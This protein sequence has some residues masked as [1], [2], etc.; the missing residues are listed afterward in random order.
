MGA[1]LIGHE[2][3]RHIWLSW[4]W[5]I[6]PSFP[7]RV[8]R[9]FSTGVREESRL[10]E[11]LRGIGATVW[12]TDPNTG[13]QWRV[14]AVRGHFGGSLDGVAQGLPEAPKTPAVLEFK[15]H[16]HKSFTQVIEQR[17]R[18]AKPQ[19]Y[20]Q[21]QIYMGLMELDRAL[22]MAVDKDTDDVYC[23][24]VHFDGERFEQ[25]MAKAERLVNAAE[26]PA[27][28]S[29]DP[30]FF[31]CKWCNFHSLC[32]GGS[33]A[34]ANCRT[35]CHATP[36]ENATWRCEHHGTELQEHK[37]R[38]GCEQHLMIPALVPYAEPIDGGSAWVAYK[39]RASGKTFVNGLG[40]NDTTY[41]PCF[42]SKELERCP[43]ELM[44]DVIETKAQFPSAT[45]VAG[46]R[47]AAA[48]DDMPNDI[49]SA[50]VKPES[51]VA[52]QK[53]TRNS[54]TLKAL[55]EFKGA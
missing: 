7:G 27:R 50:P 53:R 52:K 47:S 26:P 49:D 22:Y 24:W 41:G 20:D 5:A 28:I 35:C 19:H 51:S 9:M 45:V 40:L 16:N 38:T 17:V 30:T 29:E 55:Q 43:A 18:K 46:G 32:H 6:K 36:G 3:E 25:L 37:Q 8:L 34:E 23:E 31:I 10:V 13:G 54:A 15:T 44:P 11:E 1:S 21:M 39:H 48:F 12:E 4:R 42:S 2:C 14:S 33:A